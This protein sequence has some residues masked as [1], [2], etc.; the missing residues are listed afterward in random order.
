MVTATKLI[1]RRQS[2]AISLP[3]F[4]HTPVEND[5]TREKNPKFEKA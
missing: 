5:C 2:Q 3:P 4:F 1:I